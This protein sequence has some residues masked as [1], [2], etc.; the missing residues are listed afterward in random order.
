MGYR[1][2]K[3]RQRSKTESI[4]FTD[5]E[6]E[7]VRRPS[8]KAGKS[9]KFPWRRLCLAR[10]EQREAQSGWRTLQARLEKLPAWNLGKVKS[11]KEAHSVEAQREKESPLCYI[12]GHLSS[13]NSELEP[14]YQ[15][16]QGRVALRGDIV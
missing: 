7:S 4:H 15:K 12:D 3:A 14:K 6:E 13:Q 5:P 9:W 8:K 11:K 10:W 2:T 16:Y 1:K